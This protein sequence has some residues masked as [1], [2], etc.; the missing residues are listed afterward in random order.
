MRTKTKETPINIRAKASQR[1]LID[2][3][4]K[5]LLKSRTESILD[6]ACREAEDVLLDQRLFL[7][8]DEQYD[9]FMQALICVP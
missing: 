9:A 8:N 4:A 5:L 6:A 2:V 7:V 3:A 1:E